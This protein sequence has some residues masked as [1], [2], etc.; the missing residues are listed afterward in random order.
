MMGSGKSSVGRKLAETL[1][2]AFV[3]IDHEIELVSD[4]SIAEIFEEFGEVEFRALESRVLSRILNEEPQVIAT[5]GGA[6]LAEKNRKMIAKLAT[7]VWLDAE[8]DTLWDRVK[9]KSHR[10]L[11]QNPEPKKTLA[12][13]L[14]DR[15]PIYALSDH[16]VVSQANQSH[17][18]M[19]ERIC[20]ALG[21]DP[22]KH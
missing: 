2:V 20:I 21:I 18:A 1:G 7:S 12:K 16:R 9:N 4:R 17:E 5:G 14:E 11:L 10:P 15:N 8:L 19:V 3:D 6:F 22:K 13:L